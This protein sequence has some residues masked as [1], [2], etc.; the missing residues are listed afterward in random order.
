M[1]VLRPDKAKVLTS[2]AG[3]IQQC[4]PSLYF[5]GSNTLDVLTFLRQL[6]VFFDEPGIK[7]V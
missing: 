2:R 5:D 7:E 1:G 4:M 6:K 3:Q